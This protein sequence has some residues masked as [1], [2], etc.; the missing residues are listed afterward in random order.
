MPM[1]CAHDV[2]EYEVRVAIT[3][4][5]PLVKQ[6]SAPAGNCTAIVIWIEPATDAANSPTPTVDPGRIRGHEEPAALPWLRD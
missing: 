1:P 5:Y 3:R 6:P 2:R 4:F